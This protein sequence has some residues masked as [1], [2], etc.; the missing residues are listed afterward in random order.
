[1]KETIRKELLNRRKMMPEAEVLQKSS[2]IIAKLREL[3]VIIKAERIHVYYPIMNEVDIRP[4]IEWLWDQGKKVIMP[5]AN[6]KSKEMINYYV[7]TFGQLEETRFGLREPLKTS[8]LHLGSP[9][10]IIVPGVAFDEDKGRLGYGSGFYDRFL[11]ES[12][13]KRIG[14]AYDFQIVPVLPR[15]EHDQK[16]DVIVTEKRIIDG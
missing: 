16:M 10:V 6:F 9:D 7:I 15:E 13:S 2:S 8:P 3:P 12:N 4:F 5:R 1:M 11:Y 14:V